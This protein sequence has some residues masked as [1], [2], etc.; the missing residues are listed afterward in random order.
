MRFSLTFNINFLIVVWSSSSPFF[1]HA[2]NLNFIFFN[3]WG[4]YLQFFC[5]WLFFRR[6]HLLWWRLCWFFYWLLRSNLFFYNRFFCC[7]CIN[8]LQI[9]WFRFFLAFSSLS[10]RWFLLYQKICD[11]CIRFKFRFLYS[12][13]FIIHNLG[14]FCFWSWF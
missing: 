1:H 12:S 4:D 6:R 7:F 5:Y 9:F 2:F 11:S 10:A 3:T 13:F 14:F 8:F